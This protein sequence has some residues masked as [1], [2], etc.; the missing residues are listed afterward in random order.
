RYTEVVEGNIPDEFLPARAREVVSDFARH[1]GVAKHRGKLLC[2]WFG[3]ACKFAEQNHAFAEMLNDAGGDAVQANKT[4]SAVDLLRGEK[5]RQLFLVPQSILQ[6]DF[7]GLRPDEW[8]EQFWELII[9][10]RLER[11][12]HDITRADLFRR[13]C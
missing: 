4:N 1:A 9:R 12:E 8:R 7:R 6:R 2:S 11:D 3:L 5:P 10:R 13:L